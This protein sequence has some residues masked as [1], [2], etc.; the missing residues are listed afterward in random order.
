MKV[1]DLLPLVSTR[2]TLWVE[3]YDGISIDVGIPEFLKPETLERE[4]YLMYPAV[5]KALGG[6]NVICIRIKEIED[7][8]QK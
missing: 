8:E 2:R 7:E 5:V 1:K 3:D 6:V 4:I